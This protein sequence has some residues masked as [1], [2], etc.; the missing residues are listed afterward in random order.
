VSWIVFMILSGYWL[1]RGVLWLRGQVRFMKLRGALPARPVRRSSPAHLSEGLGGLLTR[2]FD[3]RVVLVESTRTIAEVL[4]T[5]PDVPYGCVRDFRYRM[6]LAR[7]WSAACGWLRAFES[8]A[9]ADRGLLERLGYTTATF[10][11]RHA[12]LDQR[13]RST[14]RAPALEPFDVSA[15]QTSRQGIDAMIGELERLE[16]T[17]AGA[18]ASPYRS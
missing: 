17:L 5:D 11:E 7:A 16:R 6:A 15:V 1:S 18:A 12:W 2:E 10:R 4:I 13:V 3:E 14:V 9:E 8:L